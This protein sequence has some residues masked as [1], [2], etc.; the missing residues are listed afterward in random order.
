MHLSKKI[1]EKF[2]LIGGALLL[3]VLLLYFGLKI[4]FGIFLPLPVALFAATLLFPAANKLHDRFRIPIWLTAL[5]L[6]LLLYGTIG[7]AAVAVCRWLASEGTELLK[8]I[9]ENSDALLTGIGRLP[10]RIFGEKGKLAGERLEWLRDLSLQAIGSAAE[11]LSSSITTR[12]GSLASRLPD[13]VLLGVS[14]VL[15]TYYAITSYPAICSFLNSLMPVKLKKLLTGVRKQAFDYFKK[16]I[17]ATT[18]LFILTFLLLLL[19]LSIL[20]YSR[21]FTPAL[22]IALLDMLPVLGV[23]AALLPM[24]AFRLLSGGHFVGIGLIILYAVISLLHQI[25]LPHLLGKKNGIP[26]LLTVSSMYAGYRLFGFFGL[27]LSP[28]AALLA[29]SGY[30]LLQKG[31]GEAQRSAEG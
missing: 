13:L 10:L 5:L 12:L 21:P 8:N 22:L 26:P 1:S 2:L 30:R 31:E 18:L 20:G 15:A 29:V 28:F 19:G 16:V 27:L 14:T 4:S 23:G 11:T 7:T 3:L 24:A 17:L 9:F 6:T 25:L